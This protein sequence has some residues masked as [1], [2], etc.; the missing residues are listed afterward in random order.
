MDKNKLRRIIR[1]EI[2]NLN[3][4]NDGGDCFIANGREILFGNKHKKDIL[5]HAEVSGTGRLKGRNFGHAFILRGDTKSGTVFDY[6]NGKLLELPAIIYF[7]IGNIEWNDNYYTYTKEQVSRMV[8]KYETW[9]AWD[10]K[11]KW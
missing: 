7:S 3:E 6:S 11:T 2:S 8:V 1:E 10:L 5:Y 4:S 9:G